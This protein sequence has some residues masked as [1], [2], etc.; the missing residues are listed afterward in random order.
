MHTDILIYVCIR[1]SLEKDWSCPE[2]GKVLTSRPV[3]HDVEG[4][5]ILRAH[6]GWDESRVVGSWD[7]LVFPRAHNFVCYRTA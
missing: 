5:A 1:V 6:P 3:P 4:A 7:G 2:C